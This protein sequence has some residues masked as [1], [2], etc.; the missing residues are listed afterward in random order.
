MLNVSHNDIT[1]TTSDIMK[2]STITEDFAKN[3]DACTAV[4]DTKN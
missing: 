2:R 3:V 1:Q 4:I